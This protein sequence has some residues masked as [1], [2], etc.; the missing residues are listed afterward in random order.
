M[1]N[2]IKEINRR[3]NIDNK[4]DKGVDGDVDS[5]CSDD[6]LDS[7]YPVQPRSLPNMF[8]EQCLGDLDFSFSN[9]SW[10]ENSLSE[11]DDSLIVIKHILATNKELAK[12]EIQ[13]EH[14]EE[15][16]QVIV[17][18]NYYYYYYY[19][20]YYLVSLMQS[21]LSERGD[22]SMKPSY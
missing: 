10:R 8:M 5:I 2:D 9:S 15:L 20:Y 16:A 17:F 3:I 7:S 18:R 19:Y 13:R 4:K 6:V 14:L 1:K 11:T 12:S 21:L 22:N